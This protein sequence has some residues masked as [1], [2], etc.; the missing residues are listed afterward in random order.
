MPDMKLKLKTAFNGAAREIK[1]P[2]NLLNTGAL[3]V[4]FGAACA[5]TGG[6][7]VIPGIVGILLGCTLYDACKGAAKALKQG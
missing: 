2:N 1:A 4:I 6:I 3:T 7:P 5:I